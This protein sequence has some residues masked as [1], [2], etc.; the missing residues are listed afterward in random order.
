[1]RL[2]GKTMNHTKAVRRTTRCARLVPRAL[3]VVLTVTSVLAADQA[4]AR[5]AKGGL[6]PGVHPAPA[7]QAA[8]QAAPQVIKPIRHPRRHGARAGGGGR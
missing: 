3:L 6:S 7:A 2:E 1:M 8:A 5:R 4:L